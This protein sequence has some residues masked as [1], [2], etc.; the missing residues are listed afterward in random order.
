MYFRRN[1]FRCSS[2]LANGRMATNVRHAAKTRLYDSENRVCGYALTNAAGRGVSVSLAYDGSYVTN[3]AYALP[4]GVPF[5]ARLTRVPGRR[6]LVT[7]RD[8]AFGGQSIYWH[9]TEYDLLGRPTNA[10]DSVSLVRAWLYNRRS[11]LTDANIGTDRYGYAYDTIGNRL[12]SAANSTTNIYAANSLNQYTQVGRVAPCPPTPD[13]GLG[14]VAL[15]VT[16]AYDADGNMTDDGTFSYSY[17]AENRLVSAYPVSPAA[18]SLA[19]ENRYDHRHR[20]VRKI[21]RRYDGTTWETAETHTFV[22]DENNIVMERI[23][24]ANGATRICEYFWGTDKSGTEQGAGGVGGL[25]AVSVDGAFYVPCYDHNGNIVRY[26]SE[27]GGVAARYT[28]DPYGNITDMSGALATQFSFGFSTKYHDR[29]TGLVAYQ[30]RFYSPGLGRWLNRDPIEEEGGENLYGFCDNDPSGAIDPIGLECTVGTFNVRSISISSTPQWIRSDLNA[31]ER[32]AKALMDALGKAGYASAAT[33]LATSY[34]LSALLLNIADVAASNNMSPDVGGLSR[35]VIGLLYKLRGQGPLRLDGVLKWER[36]E[37]VGGRPK[38][39]KQSDITDSDDVPIEN[40][41]V[42]TAYVA[43]F[44]NTYKQVAALRLRR[45]RAAHGH[46]ERRGRSGLRIHARRAGR[47]LHADAPQWRGIHAC[48]RTRP[49]S[50]RPCHAH[51]EP[52]QRHRRQLPCLHLRRALAPRHAQRRHV[53][54]QRA[55]RGSLRDCRRQR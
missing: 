23:A 43:N 5:S 1:S 16:P 53:R 52:R 24:L 3:M 26:V 31:L 4:G 37:C 40:L 33:S 36:C 12:W 9:S 29:E 49:V 32:D 42:P 15:P 51:R 50:P 47:G 41:G 39:V 46:I 19:V 11:E 17:D 35:S 34:G 6:E 38:W 55:R 27:T 2:L 8:Y 48:T 7:R 22:W 21:V 45:R 28:Y 30:R 54:V 20:R 13:G 25:L 10:M 14:P 44:K 18:G